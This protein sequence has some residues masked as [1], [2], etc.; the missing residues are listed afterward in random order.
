MEKKEQIKNKAVE[1]LEEKGF[2]FIDFVWRGSEQIPVL[3][4]F[5]DNETGVTT[6][7]CYV[8]SRELE[9]YID[10]NNL[11]KKYRL[12]VSSPGVEKPLVFIGQYPK[13]IGRNFELE[14]EDSG[15]IKKIEATL[16]GLRDK[17][18]VFETGKKDKIVIP[19]EFDKIKKAKV[20][21]SF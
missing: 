13:H 10:E 11:L 8:V 3:E 4:L 1:I 19:I 21:I 18:L 2:F 17:T 6:D 5:I 9:K 20:L 15:E 14:F 16:I 12:D 7:D